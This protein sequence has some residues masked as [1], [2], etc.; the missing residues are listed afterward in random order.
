MPWEDELTLELLAEQIRDF[1]DWVT[2]NKRPAEKGDNTDKIPL[3]LSSFVAVASPG[4]GPRKSCPDTHL[5]EGFQ[6]NYTYFEQITDVEDA[7]AT[8]RANCG[9]REPL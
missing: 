8:F 3:L 4:R 2:V 7:D 6:A 9:A 5:Q 1:K